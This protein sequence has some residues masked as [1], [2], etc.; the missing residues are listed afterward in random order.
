VGHTNIIVALQSAAASYK[1]TVNLL[2]QDGY[3][4]C[5]KAYRLP[6][7]YIDR[8]AKYDHNFFV[9]ERSDM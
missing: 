4:I 3:L 9:Q 7:I 8:S 5:K 1:I 2:F 6:D